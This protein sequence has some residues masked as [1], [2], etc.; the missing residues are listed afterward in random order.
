MHI[1]RVGSVAVT[2]CIT[3]ERYMTACYPTTQFTHKYLMLVIPVMVSLLYNIPKFVE[4]VSCSDE[5]KYVTRVK[6][7]FE[8]I[9]KH[10]Y[11]GN[12]TIIMNNRTFHQLII[13]MKNDFMESN[14]SLHFAPNQNIS[15]YEN[16]SLDDQLYTFLL[17]TNNSMVL[18][19]I[20]SE[21]VTTD[22][23]LYGHRMSVFR[24]NILYISIY[25]FLSDLIL[26]EIVPW[27]T[28]IV[29]TVCACKASQRFRE[30]RLRLLNR[31][32]NTRVKINFLLNYSILCE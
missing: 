18:Q 17:T 16:S 26:I 13:E 28:V 19:A 10:K 30:R 29:L 8:E 12:D 11:S 6:S 5:E 4:I 2:V 1:G 31:P 7:Y 24:T 3:V 23:D 20:Q 32:G 21:N 15:V 22:C 9:I 25:Q 27:I 14:Q